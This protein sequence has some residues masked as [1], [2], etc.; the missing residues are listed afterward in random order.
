MMP[1]TILPPIGPNPLQSGVPTDVV[2]TLTAN[3]IAE[4]PLGAVEAGETVHVAPVGAP[5][6]V[7][8]T[9]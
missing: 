9:A 4:L 8:E 1:I 3:V 2:A 7:N 6:Q 5:V